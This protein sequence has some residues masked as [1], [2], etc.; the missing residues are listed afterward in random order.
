M[1]KA[2]GVLPK[3]LSPQKIVTKSRGGLVQHYSHYDE[4]HKMSEQLF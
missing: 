3:S 2:Y 4:Q 1:K